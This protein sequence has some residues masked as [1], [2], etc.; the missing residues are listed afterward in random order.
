MWSEQ[1]IAIKTGLNIW[2]RKSIISYNLLIVTCSAC[3][4]GKFESKVKISCFQ[5]SIKLY[6]TIVKWFSTY[7]RIINNRFNLTRLRWKQIKSEEYNHMN[8][9]NKWSIVDNYL[10]IFIDLKEETFFLIIQQQ[11]LVQWERWWRGCFTWVTLKK[12]LVPGGRTWKENFFI[13]LWY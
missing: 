3:A 10:I 5:H 8:H 7:K 4:F 12:L 2:H 11:W 9:I 6:H 13:P 1:T